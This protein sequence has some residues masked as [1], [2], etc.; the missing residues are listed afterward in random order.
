MN[1]RDMTNEQLAAAV[2]EMF[3]SPDFDRI[4]FEAARRL[5]G[6][7]YKAEAMAWREAMDSGTIQI[8]PTGNWGYPTRQD[9]EDFEPVRKIRT[10]NESKEAANG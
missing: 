1:P 6:P 9:E 4:K 5:R 10:T 3:N 2:E 8:N 7:D